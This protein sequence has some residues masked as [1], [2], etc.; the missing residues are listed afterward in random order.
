MQKG[1]SIAYY[2]Q[3]LKVKALGMLTYENEFYAMM[4]AFQRW[5]L[6]LLGR[7]FIVKAD[8]QNLKFSLYQK[9]EIL[10]QK[11]DKLLSYKFLVKYN[12]GL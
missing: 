10:M 6:Y 1:H 2:N 11:N 3:A 5:R 7:L 4:S 9:V 12:K 8:H